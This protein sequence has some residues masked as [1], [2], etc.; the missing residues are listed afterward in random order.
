M[1]I[2]D[3]AAVSRVTARVTA[4]HEYQPL[5]THPDDENDTRQT[6]GKARKGPSPKDFRAFLQNR[7]LFS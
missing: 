6:A 7:D 3:S 2:T 5:P 4:L 1:S